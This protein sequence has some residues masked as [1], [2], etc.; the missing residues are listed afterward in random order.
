MLLDKYYLIKN[1]YKILYAYLAFY[2][3]VHGDK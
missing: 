3:N 2:S 1:I